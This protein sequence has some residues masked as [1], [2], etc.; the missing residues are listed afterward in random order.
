VD[1]R[2]ALPLGFKN[3]NTAI[4]QSDLKKGRVIVPS[5]RPLWAAA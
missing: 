4:C 1:G 5:D 2:Q 3:A